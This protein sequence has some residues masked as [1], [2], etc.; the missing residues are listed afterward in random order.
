MK[1]LGGVLALVALAAVPVAA[2]QA[3]PPAGLRGE[4]LAEFNEAAGKLE[5]L[6]DAIPRTSSPGGPGRAYAR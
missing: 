6:A 5:Q 2:Q 3:P 1:R 4:I